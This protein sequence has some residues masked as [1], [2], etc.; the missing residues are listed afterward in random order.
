MYNKKEV[1]GRWP[2]NLKFLLE[3]LVASQDHTFSMLACFGILLYEVSGHLLH[4]QNPM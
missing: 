3:Y 2:K 1:A 4:E